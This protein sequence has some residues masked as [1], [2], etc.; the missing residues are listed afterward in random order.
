LVAGLE[1]IEPFQVAY[2][3]LTELGWA[4]GNARSLARSSS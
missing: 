3:D 2:T 1:S 4:D